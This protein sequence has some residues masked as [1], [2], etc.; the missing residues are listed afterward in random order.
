M[1]IDHTTPHGYE[2]REV[3][4]KSLEKQGQGLGLLQQRGDLRNMG[5]LPA[6]CIRLPSL[7][8]EYR[9]RSCQI[10]KLVAVLRVGN[11]PGKVACSQCL[12]LL[13]QRHERSPH[14]SADQHGHENGKQRAAHQHRRKP[15][16]TPVENRLKFCNTRLQ[17]GLALLADLQHQ[18]VCGNPIASELVGVD[19]GEHIG[20]PAQSQHLHQTLDVS[21][22]GGVVKI[23]TI[24]VRLVFLGQQ[25]GS[26]KVHLPLDARDGSL[27]FGQPR[28]T[29]I[30]A[31]GQCR[32]ANRTAQKRHVNP[33]LLQVGEPAD[34]PVDQFLDT[35]ILC[36]A[37][38]QRRHAA[39]GQQHDENAKARTE[40]P[41]QGEAV[42]PCEYT[43]HETSPPAVPPRRSVSRLSASRSH[44]SAR[45]S[46]LSD[47]GSVPNASSTTPS[48]CPCSEM[49]RMIVTVGM[50]APRPEPIRKVAPSP[51][52]TIRSTPL[53]ATSPSS[54]SP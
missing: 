1:G 45:S 51:A 26:G 21:T 18:L 8:L 22:I 25:Q 34:I 14:R 33:R 28:G 2:R 39:Q 27:H 13:A 52:R 44:R 15:S 50:L 42:E 41:S 47:G 5:F 38:V 37:G 48:T 24:E 17:E 30:R 12:H 10:A 9:D 31:A 35:F 4:K 40:P 23:Q 7:R 54:P 16:Q 49:G 3:L 36:V 46:I 19:P 20:L 11:A 6:L 53:R 29:L 43:A 32:H